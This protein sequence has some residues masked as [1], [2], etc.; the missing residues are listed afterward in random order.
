MSEKKPLG[1]SQICNIIFFIE[2][3]PPPP[4]NFSENSS[5]LVAPPF[6]KANAIFEMTDKT[7]ELGS[8][9]MSPV[10]Q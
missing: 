6:P 8:L 3:D 2:N 4:W 7:E 1:R 5:N 9:V 10:Q